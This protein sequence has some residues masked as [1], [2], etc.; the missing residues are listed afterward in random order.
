MSSHRRPSWTPMARRRRTNSLLPVRGGLVLMDLFETCCQALAF[1]ALLLNVLVLTASHQYHEPELAS[2]LDEQFALKLPAVA[3][4]LF[5]A[6]F[7]KR[8]GGDLSRLPIIIDCMCVGCAI[9]V[10]CCIW[11][12]RV[13]LAEHRRQKEGWKPQSGSPVAAGGREGRETDA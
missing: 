7:Y 9:Y 8:D 5:G 4:R 2:N 11:R 1:F 6:C 10:I 3:L 13:A 12:L